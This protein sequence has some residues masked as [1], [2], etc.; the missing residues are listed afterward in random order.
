[1]RIDKISSSAEYQMKE[2]LKKLKIFRAK[3][4]ISSL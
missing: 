1:M 4:W 2:Q 3:F